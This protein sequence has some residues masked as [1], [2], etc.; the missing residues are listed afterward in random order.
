MLAHSQSSSGS[1]RGELSRFNFDIRWA[2]AFVALFFVHNEAHEIAHTTVGRVIC[3]AWGPRNFNTWQVA[4]QDVRPELIFVPIAGLAVSYGMMW[5]GYYLLRPK[6]SAARQSVGLCLIFAAFPFGRI[7][8]VAQ[9]AGDE[10]V[11]LRGIFPGVNPLLR[12]VVGLTIVSLLVGPPLYRAFSV[13]PRQGRL[14]IFTGL[15]LLPNA[16]FEILIQ[17]VANPLL[18]QGVLASEGILGSPLF[19]NVWTGFWLLVLLV[20]RQYIP[21]ALAP[22]GGDTPE[23]H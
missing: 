4:C 20:S 5:T 6:Q 18:R 7:N 9:S 2:V 3:G 14:L 13:L 19:V 16:L 21:T 8:T 10:M 1:D 11:L 15:L 23:S 12:L 22:S 17:R